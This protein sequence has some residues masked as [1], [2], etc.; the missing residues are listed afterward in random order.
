MLEQFGLLLVKM[1]VE[2]LKDL[3]RIKAER[4]N[5]C[6]ELDHIN[7]LLAALKLGHVVS[8]HTEAVSDHLLSDT[9]LHSKILEKLRE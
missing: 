8:F 9:S 1:S 5:V 6:D 7:P 3:N 4:L 2:S